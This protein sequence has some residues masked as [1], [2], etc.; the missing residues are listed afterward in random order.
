[1]DL[2]TIMAF[3]GWCSIINIGIFIYWVAIVLLAPNWIYQWS[4]RFFT[5]SQ[6]QF[7]VIQYCFMGAFKLFILLFNIV[8]YFALRIIS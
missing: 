5:M 3:L 1:M 7:T 4:N 2:I 6:E 8:P